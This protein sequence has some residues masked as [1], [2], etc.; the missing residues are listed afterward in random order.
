VAVEG[1]NNVTIS[2][3]IFGL[4]G[5]GGGGNSEACVNRN[6]KTGA[7]EY[8]DGQCSQYDFR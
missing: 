7:L 4:L 2:G 8:K 6:E 1:T 5:I 3:P